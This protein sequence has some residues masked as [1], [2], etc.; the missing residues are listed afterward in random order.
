MSNLRGDRHEPEDFLYQLLSCHSTCQQFATCIGIWLSGRTIIYKVAWHSSGALRRTSS[1]I[2][3]IKAHRFIETHRVSVRIWGFS[4]YLCYSASRAAKTYNHWETS[5]DV[6]HSI[7]GKLKHMFVFSKICHARIRHLS[8]SSRA[9]I[10]D[11]GRPK[12]LP[13]YTIES[14]DEFVEISGS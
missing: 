7:S 9:W 10:R 5:R 14:L 13:L 1:Q 8:T 2:H 4:L 6:S 3:L 11:L 12:T